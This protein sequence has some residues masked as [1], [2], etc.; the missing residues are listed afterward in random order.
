V[1]IVPVCTSQEAEGED[2][3]EEDDDEA[4][5]G[6]EGAD[7]VDE[8]EDALVEADVSREADVEG[9]YRKVGGGRRHTIHKQK[10]PNAA[11]KACVVRPLAA[12]VG[13]VE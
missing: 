12:F 9:Q 4:D 3:R 13:S 5:V 11:L 8:A 2:E 6:A 10:K 7:H 1:G